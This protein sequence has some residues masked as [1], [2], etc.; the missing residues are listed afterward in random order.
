M[1]PKMAHLRTARDRGDR[2]VVQARASLGLLATLTALVGAPILLL[3]WLLPAAHVLPMFSLVSLAAAGAAALLAW[4]SGAERDSDGITLWD[5]AGALAFF[6]FAAGML[7]EPA[8]VAQL[9]GL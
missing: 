9:F 4:C 8:H 2:F 6:G 5:F 3:V 1:N 7:S